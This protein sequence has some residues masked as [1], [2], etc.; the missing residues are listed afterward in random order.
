M[1]ARNAEPV[2]R[3]YILCIEHVVRNGAE[4]EVFLFD[5]TCRG[6][7][8]H[9][10]TTTGT[11]PFFLSPA[12]RLL[13]NKSAMIDTSG[14]EYNERLHKFIEAHSLTKIMT[15]PPLT[16]SATCGTMCRCQKKKK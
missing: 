8:Y 1:Q 15:R 2:V 7:S 3:R 4:L 6:R 12:T 16:S 14:A 13:G 10:T 11:Y 5:L 9:N